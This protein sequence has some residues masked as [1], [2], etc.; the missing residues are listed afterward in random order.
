VDLKN[1]MLAVKTSK[2]E[3][4]VEIPIFGP[5][6]SVLKECK[7]N[8]SEYVFP[9]AAHMLQE[10]PNGLT[11][12]FK[13]I[14]ANAFNAEEPAALPSTI[15]AA[16]IEAEG[17][18]TIT[19]NIPEGERRNRML[20]V[21]RRYCAGESIRQIEKA[22]YCKATVST[23]LHAVQDMVGKSFITG[24]QEPGMKAHIARIT[25]VKREHGQRAASIRDWH[26]LRATFVTLALAAGVPV[27]LVRRVTG[28]AT[29]E[30]VLK[31]Y[32]RPDREQ[33]RQALAG[34]MPGILTGGKLKRLKSADE[35]SVLA[36]KVASG[37][38]TDEDKARL[39]ELA[40]TV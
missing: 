15:P 40:A 8:H 20:D 16:E 21:F 26:A 22:G 39:R 6:L 29:V 34:A 9:H 30:I 33:F 10:N 3:A 35:L 25:R 23:D 19:K 11:W 13:K 31:H 7:G 17:K 24:A 14:V 12:R 32:F 4:E 38:A 36:G 28:H 5:L 37:S 18:A 27:E 2:T 1:G